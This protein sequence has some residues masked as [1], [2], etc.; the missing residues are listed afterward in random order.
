VAIPGDVADKIATYLAADIEEMH[1]H[2][3]QND[4]KRS[5]I[6]SEMKELDDLHAS[7]TGKSLLGDISTLENIQTK[8]PIPKPS[9]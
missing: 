8:G 5:E 6:I 7:L 1:R 9:A 3:T 2:L 4:G